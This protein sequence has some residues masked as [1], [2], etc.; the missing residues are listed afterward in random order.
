MQ[1][2]AIER[3]VYQVHRVFSS[4]LGRDKLEFSAAPKD[5]HFASD[6]YSQIPPTHP[7]Y[8]AGE[9]MTLPTQR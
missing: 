8:K 4:K 5:G 7:N 1:A 3:L 2:D 9:L 6:G